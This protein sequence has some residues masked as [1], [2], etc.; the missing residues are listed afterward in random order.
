[1]TREENFEKAYERLEAILEKM[2]SEQV[3]LDQ[4]LSLYEEADKL[5]VLCQKRL[6]EAEKKIEILLK[7]RE[8]DLQL[9]EQNRPQTQN[10]LASEQAASRTSSL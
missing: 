6:I 7:N 10:F 1:M 4:A 9:D 2:H 3:S 5:I 8:G